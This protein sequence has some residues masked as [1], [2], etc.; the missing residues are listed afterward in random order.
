ML[1]KPN[2]LEPSTHLT[3]KYPSFIR[4]IFGEVIAV[5]IRDGSLVE[6]ARERVREK[7]LYYMVRAYQ[8]SK[9]L[10]WFGWVTISLSQNFTIYSPKN[11]RKLKL[12]SFIPMKYGTPNCKSYECGGSISGNKRPKLYEHWWSRAE[13][14]IHLSLNYV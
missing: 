3:T 6:C 7:S 13:F 9:V 12:P 8:F 14:H 2:K 10:F 4:T 1:L 5:G 11:I